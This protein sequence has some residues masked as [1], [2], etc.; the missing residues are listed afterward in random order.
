MGY[1]GGAGAGDV[2][3]KRSRERRKVVSEFFCCVTN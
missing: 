1:L 3:G 2:A